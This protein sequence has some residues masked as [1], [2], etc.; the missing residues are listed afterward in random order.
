MFFGVQFESINPERLLVGKLAAATSN[1]AGGGSAGGSTSGTGTQSGGG[2]AAQSKVATPTF[3][4]ASWAEGETLTVE[5]ATETDGASIYYTTNGDTPT[6]E[7]S[8]YDSTNKITLSATTTIKAIA[9]KEG[10]T[11]S[12]VATK[13]YTKP[14]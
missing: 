3:D 10:M 1:N 6:A 11:A 9:V 7:S 5:L 8:A 12:D 4:P 2:S 13:A 14:E